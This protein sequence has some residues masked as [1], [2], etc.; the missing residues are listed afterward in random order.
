[1]INFED[2]QLIEGAYF[3]IDG[4]K[5]PV[6]MP[7]YSGKTPLSAENMNKLQKDLNNKIEN[8]VGNK[9]ENG[10]VILSNG[11][12]LQWGKENI[13]NFSSHNASLGYSYTKEF[14]I[15]F[16]E[17]CVCN[18]CSGYGAGYARTSILSSNLTQVQL[19]CDAKVDGISINWFAIGI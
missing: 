2:G 11:L 12:K 7:I 4:V 13:N 16:T 1:M 6:K 5:Y 18:I 9:E 8:Y 17:F 10:Y 19:G 3:E 15:P 14:L